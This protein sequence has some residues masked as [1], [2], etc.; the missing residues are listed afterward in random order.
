MI[1]ENVIGGEKESDIGV[2]MNN[3]DIN[4]DCEGCII[5]EIDITCS[6]FKNPLTCPCID[7][8]IKIMC[9][10]SCEEFLSYANLTISV[11]GEKRSR[12]R[13]TDD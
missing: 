7:C 10:S 1:L 4:K 13:A 8:L 11:N 6:W 2:M 12:V 5:L 9:R 3:T